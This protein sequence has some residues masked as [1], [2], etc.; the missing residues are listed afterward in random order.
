M[1]GARPSGVT[2]PWAPAD[3]RAY[4]DAGLVTGDPFFE[5]SFG[6]YT[7]ENAND[8]FPETSFADAGIPGYTGSSF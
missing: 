5:T 6:P 3:H 4:A 1:P 2:T 7:P 8:H